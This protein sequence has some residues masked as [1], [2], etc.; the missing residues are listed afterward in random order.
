MIMTLFLTWNKKINAWSFDVNINQCSKNC[1]LMQNGL[2]PYCIS[3][4]ERF[5]NFIAWHKKLDENEKAIKKANFERL[6]IIEIKEKR[7]NLIRVY[8]YGQILL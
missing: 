8:S 6:M 7:A 5:K 2:K 3:L 4:K 1:E